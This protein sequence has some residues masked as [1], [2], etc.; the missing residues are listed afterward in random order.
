LGGDGQLDLVAYAEPL[1]G[2]AS[3][4]PDGGFGPLRTFPVLPNI[5]WHDPNLRFMDVDGDGLGDVLITEDDAFIWYRSLAKDGFEHARRVFHP[6]DEDKGAAIMFADAEQSVQLADMS[7]DGLVDIVRVRNGEVCY[8]PNLG[9]GRFGAKV[10]L[11]ASPL[12]AGI[13]DF[14]GRRVRFGDAD[15]SGTSDIFYLGTTGVTL[16]Y[17]QSGNALSAATPIT[18]LPVMDSAGQVSVVDLLGTG[19]A[20]LVWSSPLPRDA[21]R[22]IMYVDLMGGVK[23]HLMRSVVNNLGAQTQITYAPST[24]FYLADKAAATP[25]L[26]RLAFPVHVVERV[27]RFDRISDTHLTSRRRCGPDRRKRAA[28]HRRGDRSSGRRPL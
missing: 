8:W 11:E 2:Y 24:K 6:R 16:Y 1:S 14:D 4:T 10:T 21:Q 5:D 28:R 26:T 3:R 25:W 20:S 12:F 15:G 17:N 19:T 7:G 18:A 22:P 13:E 9:Y 23:P 27:D